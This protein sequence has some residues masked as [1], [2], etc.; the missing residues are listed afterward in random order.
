[1][2]LSIGNEG[3][4]AGRMVLASILEKY[5]RQPE[6]LIHILL[7]YQQSKDQNY[8]SEEEVI[9]IARELRIPESRIYTIITF[10][11]LF[12]LT[13]RGKYIIQVCNDAPCHVNGSADIV[14]I[15]EDSLK[16]EMGETTPDGVFTLEYTSCIGCCDKAPAIRIGTEIFG[17]L[18]EAEISRIITRFR[19]KYDAARE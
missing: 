1:V 2:I 17:N 19:R 4:E 7:E 12:S 6:N 10:Y 5:Q 8:I 14:D 16:I 3:K 13:P 11:S 9:R 15:L 18:T